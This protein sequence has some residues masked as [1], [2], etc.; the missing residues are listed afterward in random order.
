[1]RNVSGVAGNV[2]GNLVIPEKTA[3]DTL[4]GVDSLKRALPDSAGRRADSLKR[5]PK[6]RQ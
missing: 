3:A 6:K 2:Q 5:T 1:V 4:K